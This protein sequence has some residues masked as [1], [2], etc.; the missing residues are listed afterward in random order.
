MSP[1]ESRQ[2]ALSVTWTWP[3]VVSLLILAMLPVWGPLIPPLEGMIA[4]VT[5]KVTF[6]DQTPVEGGLNVRMAYVKMRDCE[7]I[8]VSLD[9]NGVPIEF[10]PVSGS[11]DKL[12]TKGTG[13]QISRV[14]FVGNDSTNGLRLR[15]VHRCTPLWTVVTIAY[16]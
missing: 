11:T 6:I 1:H 4:P 3:V 7:I 9:K 8:G 13:P 16:P 5:T 2:F 10:S 15:F 12:L 14:W